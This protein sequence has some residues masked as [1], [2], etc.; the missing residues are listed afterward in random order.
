MKYLD[1]TGVNN[2]VNEYLND[3]SFN[4]A[5]LIDG[6]WGS[7]KTYYVKNSLIPSLEEKMKNVN[8]IRRPVYISL[9]GIEDV[10]EL[11]QKVFLIT[12]E[13]SISKENIINKKLNWLPY[14][15]CGVDILLNFTSKYGIE[16]RSISRALHEFQGADK[17]LFIFDDLERCNA[18]IKTV[19]GYINELVEHENAKVIIVANEDEIRDVKTQKDIQEPGDESATKNYNIKNNT[20]TT[21]S[22]DEFAI[23]DIEYGRIKEK[24]VGQTIYFRPD[25]NK[26]IPQIVKKY[27]NDCTLKTES[28]ELSN[29]I[30]DIYKE[31]EYYNLRT[32]QSNLALLKMI[33]SEENYTYES[34]EVKN[35]VIQKI[36]TAIVKVSIWYKNTNTK[37]Q[38]KTESEYAAINLDDDLVSGRSYVFSFKFIHDYIYYAIFNKDDVHRVMK[39]YIHLVTEETKEKGIKEFLDSNSYFWESDDLK[40]IENVNCIFVQLKKKEIQG[41]YYGWVLALICQIQDTGLP[42][43]HDVDDFL[44][45]MK[46]NIK[47]GTKFNYYLG[48]S[49]FESDE[50]RNQYNEKIRELIAIQDELDEKSMIYSINDTLGDNQGWGENF[51]KY[52]NDHKQ[53]F[54]EKKSFFENIDIEKCEH[55]LIIGSSRD[56]SYFYEGIENVYSFSNIDEFFAVDLKNL[57]ELLTWINKISFV[58]NQKSYLKDFIKRRIIKKLE[59]A[60]GKIKQSPDN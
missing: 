26:V 17:Y 7:G 11:R 58:E 32:L 24:L 20:E 36:I 6:G 37:Y 33:F 34:N 59:W 27:L 31:E 12:L 43:D 2:V 41:S 44:E 14:L 57:N 30:I 10:L 45:I 19:L 15:D 29:I 25:I 46:N 51:H 55:S 56:L 5:I 9:Y 23:S 39:Q 8:H 4:C 47:E 21:A 35:T 40:I 49:F 3:N 22:K 52:C 13:N 50:V 28:D 54:L 48:Y 53:Q 42:I 18:P 60:V 38:W 16:K 1:E